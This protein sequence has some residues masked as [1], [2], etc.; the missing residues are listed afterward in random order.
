M[1]PG[2]TFKSFFIGVGLFFIVLFARSYSIEVLGEYTLALSLSIPVLL[3]TL[4]DLNGKILAGKE[5]N[6]F[7]FV[8]ILPLLITFI[9]TCLYFIFPN[10][11][12]IVLTITSVFVLKFSELVSEARHTYLRRDINYKEY[13]FRILFR[14][15]VV[16]MPAIALIVLNKHHLV[17]LF[18]SAFISVLIMFYNCIE[19][20]KY[21]WL[22]QFKYIEFIQYLQKNFSLGVASMVKSMQTYS[23]RYYIVMFHGLEVLGYMAPAFYALTVFANLST[24]IDGY[25]TPKLIRRIN[26][27]K[28]SLNI[29]RYRYHILSLAIFLIAMTLSSYYFSDYYYNLFFPNRANDYSSIIV[30]LSFG[31]LFYIMRGMLRVV[32]YRFGFISKQF[33]IQVSSLIIMLILFFALDSIYNLNGIFMA[34]VL[35]NIYTVVIY[36]VI[37]RHKLLKLFN[38]GRKI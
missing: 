28:D 5:N 9:L 17:V 38:I 24:I 36:I 6:S 14:Y 1:S 30:I 8:L 33:K 32:S 22:Y 2:R 11:K 19:L 10:E 25:A 26:N 4:F 27:N 31:L 20:K 37:I 3:F 34:F 18:A 21:G 12:D 16:Y 29:K 13:F 23:L 35:A 15:L 7:L